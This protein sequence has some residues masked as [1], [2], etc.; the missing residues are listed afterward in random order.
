M[1]DPSTGDIVDAV[2]Q[3]PSAFCIAPHDK[4]HAQGVK[5]SCFN[6]DLQS[7]AV[8]PVAATA[9]A[10]PDSV[11]PSGAPI[12]SPDGKTRI[13]LPKQFSEPVKSVDVKSGK[14]LGSPKL[15]TTTK[16]MPVNLELTRFLGDTLYLDFWLEPSG[17][18][19]AHLYDPRTWRDLATI[20]DAS[21]ER[22][23]HV[24]GKLWAFVSADCTTG[25]EAAPPK[26]KWIDVGTGAVA[27]TLAL[28]WKEC[29]Q[30]PSRVFDSGGRLAVVSSGA[31]GE[32]A[33]I[34][35][36]AHTLVQHISLP[37][38]AASKK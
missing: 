1:I 32:V 25:G 21:S 29:T 2:G 13:L 33:V 6:V 14:A 19:Q 36:S 24:D 12:V 34:D 31:L 23:V 15:N 37:R 10:V 18:H 17:Y 38:C 27:A 22:I 11:T 7:G 35:E 20:D 28:P 8:T 9:G 3:G 30:L 5:A 16:D 26:V 4:D